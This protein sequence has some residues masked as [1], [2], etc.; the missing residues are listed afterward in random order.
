MYTFVRMMEL[1][2]KTILAILGCEVLAIFLVGSLVLAI[3]GIFLL[4]KD[5]ASDRNRKK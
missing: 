3:L 1:M 5:A 4:L 2:D